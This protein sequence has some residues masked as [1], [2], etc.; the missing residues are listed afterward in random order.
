MV[1]KQCAVLKP[2]GALGL[3][4]AMTQE[5][6][7]SHSKNL[8]LLHRCASFAA[9]KMAQTTFGPFYCLA[10]GRASLGEEV[11]KLRAKAS[12]ISYFLH[13]KRQ[14]NHPLPLILF[15]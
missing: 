15:Q 8:L 5:E 11:T 9:N 13:T 3:A 12:S 7:F 10:L 1:N 14:G 4:P 6:Y 2:L